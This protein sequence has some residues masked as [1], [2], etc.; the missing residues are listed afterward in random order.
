MDYSDPV[1]VP[2]GASMKMEGKGYQY[3]KP[4]PKMC[5]IK[6]TCSKADLFNN[7]VHASIVNKIKEKSV[8][9]AKKYGSVAIPFEG[10]A[11]TS[12]M[13]QEIIRG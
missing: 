1:F 7:Y 13:Y 9:A 3:K 10:C 12:D 2:G 11:L 4:L 8:M 6:V 5:F